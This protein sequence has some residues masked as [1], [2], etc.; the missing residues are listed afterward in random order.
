MG[1]ILTFYSYKGGVGRSMA[2]ANIAVL[3]AQKGKKVLVIDWDLEAP[4]LEYYFRKYVDIEKVAKIPGVINLIHSHDHIN[5]G[6][7]AISWRDC[8][9]SFTI[10]DSKLSLIASGRKKGDN[11]ESYFSLVR[12]L[13][14]D[15]FYEEKQGGVYIETLRNEWKAEY[16][17]VLI[18]SRTGITDIG[19]I[20][21][22]QLPD[23][24]IML[25]N[26]NEQ[27][28]AGIAEVARKANNARK[29][30]PFDRYSLLIYPLASRFDSQ[31]EFKI[32]QEWLSKI[33]TELRDYFSNWLPKKIDVRSFIE[34]TKIPYSPFFSFGEK[35]PVIDQG[36]SDPTS[37]GFAYETISSII[38]GNFENIENVL[39]NRGLI[40]SDIVSEELI[41]DKSSL[42]KGQKSKNESR[43]GR[44]LSQRGMLSI[45]MLIASMGALGTALVG[46]ARL[47]LNIFGVGWENSLSTL[48]L[49]ASVIGLAYAVGWI[50][51]MI[52]IRVYGNLV[53]PFIIN[54]LMW[55]CLIGVCT[56]YL[57]ILQRLYGQQYDLLHF[58]AYLLAM[59]A[60]LGAIVGLHL[61]VEDHDLRPFSIPLLLISM[62]HLG[63]IV[64]RYVFTAANEA[65]LWRDLLFF[66]AMASFGFVML[67]NIGL[68]TPVRTRLTNYFDRSTNVIRTEN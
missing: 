4:G 27:S 51:G 9:V 37:L 16:D 20:C 60:G 14:V 25:F 52:A 28:L 68:L 19:G 24:L 3:L 21:T 31:A 63:L 6:G 35:L 11:E 59:A 65:Y 30:L 32:S 15:H 41:E 58:W 5:E 2:L 18:D 17:F 49:Q 40:E 36:V 66:I 42:D 1:Q 8:V 50:T 67:T 44:R 43:K 39:R 64:F 10:A 26:A 46:G 53:L 7:S 12:N 33:A 47:V 38:A 56:L 13:D 29:K 23:I 22:I 61:I 48:P 45:L 55:G 34:V 57:L 62:I 54:Y